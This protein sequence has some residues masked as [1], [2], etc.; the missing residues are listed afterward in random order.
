MTDVGFPAFEG[1]TPVLPPQPEG[2]GA[3]QATALAR[4]G[5]TRDFQLIAQGDNRLLEAAMPLLGASVRLRGLHHH[6][7][8]EVLHAR[9]VNEVQ[10]FERAIEAAGYD[11]AT[12]VAARYCLCAMV[13]E[14]ILSTHWGA[15]SQW[16]ERPLLSVFHNETWG[17]EKVFAILDRVMA[18]GHRFFDLME[19][20]YY[21]IALGFEG[22]FHVMHN[23]QAKL[24]HLLDTLHRQIERHRGEPAGRLTDPE[25]RIAQTRQTL[26]ARLPLW[27]YPLLGLAAL[28]VI[29]LAFDIPLDRQIDAIRDSINQTLAAADERGT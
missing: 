28:V 17:G 5:S 24:D 6:D 14:S 27:A 20:I 19:L 18:E 25:T 1:E 11:T 2:Q 26:R 9:M 15:D 16:P 22:K 4:P 8:V 23:G 13:D 29:H 12:V 3:R 21:C 7:D 10:T